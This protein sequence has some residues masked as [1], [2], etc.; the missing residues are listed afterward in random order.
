MSCTKIDSFYN[1]NFY[2]G[3]KEWEQWSRGRRLIVI[4]IKTWIIR[5]TSTL[6]ISVG[7]PSQILCYRYC[8]AHIFI[9]LI[10]RLTRICSG[11]TDFTLIHLFHK[12]TKA[13]KLASE[14]SGEKTWKGGRCQSYKGTALW[15]NT[16][17]QGFLRNLMQH[18]HRGLKCQIRWLPP[19]RIWR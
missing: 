10:G 11:A 8:L 1:M 3:C 18:F 12:F 4:F 14:G 17:K 7:D 13:N 6:L 9:S 16:L 19:P 5:T 2:I 15:R